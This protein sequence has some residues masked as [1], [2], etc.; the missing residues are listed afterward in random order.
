MY[1]FVEL[2]R[3]V[4]C[5]AYVVLTYD[6]VELGV[7]YGNLVQGWLVEGDLFS[8]AWPSKEMAAARLDVLYRLRAA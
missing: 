2:S 5:V 8:G 3:T 7:V 6:E 4:V 1:G